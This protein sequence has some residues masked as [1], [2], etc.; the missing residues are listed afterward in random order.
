[1][2]ATSTTG[3]VLS[4]DL[5]A[6]SKKVAG[7]KSKKS[8]WVTAVRFFAKNFVLL[9]FI[10]WWFTVR[11][12]SE[13]DD[14]ILELEGLLK[15][16]TKMIEVQVDVVDK[17]IVNEV[18]E[19]RKE[20]DVKL[21]KKNELRKE[22]DVKIEQKGA[23][24]KNELR[25]LETKGEKLERYLSELKVDDLLTKEEFEKFVEVLK[26]VKGNEHEGGGLDEIREFAR[27]VVESEIEKHA[28]D[29]LGRVDY[30]LANGGAAVVTHSKPYGKETLY[31]LTS[32]NGVHPKA[33]MMLK[34]SFGEP[35]QC[36]P[37]E[38]SRGFVQIRLHAEIIPEAITLEHVAKLICLLYLPEFSL[39]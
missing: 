4:Q 13:Y 33:N 37:L 34:P 24:L 22:M 31:L 8:N 6:A 15:K 16:M 5:G 26:N 18:G 7:G 10:V 14:R 1:M 20:M 30:A 32:R 19:L 17:K 35:W 23:F 12:F 38:G 21:S 25:K 9:G 29:G 39:W 27:G 2:S 36:F 28:A 3:N 11:F